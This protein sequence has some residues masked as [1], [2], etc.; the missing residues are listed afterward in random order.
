MG[1]GIIGKGET[2]IASIARNFKGRM[3]DPDS[4]VYL[5]SPYSVAAAAVFGEVTDPRELLAE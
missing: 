5:G 2:C 4:N 1:A 3:G